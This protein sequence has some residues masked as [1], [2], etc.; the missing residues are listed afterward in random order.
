MR[1]YGITIALLAAVPHSLGASISA[2]QSI[3]LRAT[4]HGDSITHGANGDWTWRYRLW[5]WMQADPAIEPQFVGPFTGTHLD[6]PNTEFDTGGNYHAG[7]DATFVASGSAHAAHWGRSLAQS[8]ETVTQWTRDYQPDYL[9]VMLGFNDLGWFVSDVN[10]TLANMERF[11]T[12]A[13]AVKPSVQFFIANIVDRSFLG[14]REDLVV[15][16]KEYNQR[17]PGLLKSLDT[18]SSSIRVVDVNTAYECRPEGC[19][20]G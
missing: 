5:Q 1:L 8:A 4:I 14:G 15:N 18:A 6:N 13:R 11:V 7:T 2:R 20:D 9:L 3:T 10:G 17:L 16:T 19:P 12:R